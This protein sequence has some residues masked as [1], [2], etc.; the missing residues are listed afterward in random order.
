MPT[1]D[2]C[3]SQPSDPIDSPTLAPLLQPA[4]RDDILDVLPVPQLPHP[5]FWWS[6]LWCLGF[7][8]VLNIIVMGVGVI[9]MIVQI[10]T[11]ADPPAYAEKIQTKEFEQT[12][13]Y[14]ELMGTVLA[15][16]LLLAELSAIAFAWLVI[17]LVVGKE[18]TRRLALRR[19]G[20]VHFLLAL[21]GLPA[22]MVV[23][24]GL[25]LLASQFLPGFKDLGIPNIEDMAKMFQQWPVWFGVAVIGLGAAASEELWCRGF[26]GRGLVGRYGAVRGVLLTSFFFG[27]LHLDPPHAVFAVVVGVALHF[28]YL[29]SRSLWIPMCLHLLNNSQS[30]MAPKVPAF[31]Y[32]DQMAA[33]RPFVVYPAAV[34]LLAAA[35][36]A[37]YQ[38][39]ARL[40]TQDDTGQQPWRPAFPGVEHPPAGSSTIV[41]RPWP[42]WLSSALVAMAILVFGA[43]L[44][45]ALR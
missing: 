45:G 23:A 43:S 15:P 10:V 41:A 4:D 39:R 29:M 12:E 25:Y 31:N 34:F 35:G 9:G 32:L 37:L 44:Y 22:L 16:A 13:E 7:A 19:P 21:A 11:A 30:V 5:G 6:L 3:N 2:P 26:L 18:W 28:T 38:S 8:I 20:A 33:Q 1:E 36:W 42:G 17:R 27:L 24:N 40:V 14:F